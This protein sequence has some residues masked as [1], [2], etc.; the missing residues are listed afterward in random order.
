MLGGQLV[1]D[2]SLGV[3]LGLAGIERVEGNDELER[4]KAR[5]ELQEDGN[6]R[7]R[8]GNA[9]KLGM[10]DDVLGC[11]GAE[12]LIEGNAEE[13]LGAKAEICVWSA[14]VFTPGPLICLAYR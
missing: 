10:V 8:A 14:A 2:C 3:A 6:V 4:R 1:Q 13:G 7:E 5:S 11:V 12:S 9:G